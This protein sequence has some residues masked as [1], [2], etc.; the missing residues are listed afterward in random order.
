MERSREA[1]L[2]AD[3]PPA[4]PPKKSALPKDNDKFSKIYVTMYKKYTKEDFLKYLNFK[5]DYGVQG[6]LYYGAIRKKKHRQELEDTLKSLGYEVSYEVIQE[7]GFYEN[8]IVLN[9]GGKKIWYG[10]S[11]GGAY[12][13]E[14]LHLACLLGSKKNIL[15]GSCGGLSKNG[16]VG[17]IVLA[18]ASYGN[19]ST[20]RM[21]QPDN[22]E[23]TYFPD[24][25]LTN[26]IKTRIN[27]KYRV[28]EGKIMTCQAA[29]MESWE[30]VLR[31][32]DEGY[33]GVEME[34]STFFAVSKY[35]SVPSAAMVFIVDNLIKNETLMD[36]KVQNLKQYFQEVKTEL[37]R[38]AL[39]ELLT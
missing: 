30:D 36:E 37:F 31:W 8:V 14:V 4:A 29:M 26:N 25:D 39:E 7:S 27:K 2:S 15:L 19:E 38:V 16:T 21:Y 18:N 1:A 17:D 22:E 9:I 28:I 6:V 12:L 13:S 33:V 20:T 24:E 34:S 35:F 32:S 5:D 3:R 10:T 23:F 11:Y